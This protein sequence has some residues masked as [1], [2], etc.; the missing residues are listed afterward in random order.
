M[1]NLLKVLVLFC[2]PVIVMAQGGLSGEIN[3]RNIKETA[4]I[5]IKFKVVHAN[6]DGCLSLNTIS[7]ANTHIAKKEIL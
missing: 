5:L 3:G 7:I 6:P 4:N 1:K 2:F